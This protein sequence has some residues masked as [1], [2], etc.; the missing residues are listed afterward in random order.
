MGF[1]C[2]GSR[3]GVKVVG[4]MKGVNGG[5]RKGVRGGRMRVYIHKGKR[6]ERQERERNVMD[7]KDTQTERRR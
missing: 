7:M 3:K 1:N 4:S 5:Q 2:E 6:E